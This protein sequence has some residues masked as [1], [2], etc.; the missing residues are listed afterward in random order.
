MFL[1]GYIIWVA[2]FSDCLLS[3]EQ[4]SEMERTLLRFLLELWEVLAG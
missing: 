3:V 2:Q 1:D 4:S